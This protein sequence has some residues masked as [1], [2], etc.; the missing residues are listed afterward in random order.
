MIYIIHKTLVLLKN[1]LNYLNDNILEYFFKKYNRL[2][3]FEKKVFF[4]K[5]IMLEN[6]RSEEKKTIKDV[7]NLFR[8][9]NELNYTGIK[10]IINLFTHKKKLKKL[11]TEYL[12]MLRIFLSM[13]N[14]KKIILNQ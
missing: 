13:K 12:E 14:K 5:Y 11:R 10:D 4:S 1:H 3:F 2:L 7:R 9:K 8:L 6:P